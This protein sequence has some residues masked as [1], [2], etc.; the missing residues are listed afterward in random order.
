MLCMQAW[1]FTLSTCPILSPGIPFYR[2]RGDI[3]LYG[4]RANMDYGMDEDARQTKA[5]ILA[6]LDGSCSSILGD[7]GA[8]ILSSEIVYDTL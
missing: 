8:C 4:V 1:V 7:D 6:W 5:S 3:G 2:P